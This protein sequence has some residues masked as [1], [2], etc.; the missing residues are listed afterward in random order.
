MSSCTAGP[1][2]GPR[3]ATPAEG[4]WET[5]GPPAAQ[6]SLT[7]APSTVTGSSG[8]GVPRASE[9]DAVPRESTT[10]GT[11]SSSGPPDAVGTSSAATRVTVTTSSQPPPR[12]ATILG[13][14]DVLLHP[15]LWA[16]A[17]ADAASSG[18]TG[19]GA[20]RYDFGPIFAGV[21]GEVA[22][23]D[24]AICELETPVAAPEGPFSGWPRFD[25]PPQVLGTLKQIGYDSCTT[26]SNHTLDQGAAGVTSTLDALD[27]A[28]LAHTGSARSAAEASQ[29]L[30]VTTDSGVRVGQLAYTFGFNGL[31]RPAGKDWMANLID[32]PDILAAAK[33]TRE[34]G[35]DI[36]VLSL[37]WGTEYDHRVTATQRA[38]AREL[39][40]SP[41]IDLILGDHAHVVQPMQRIDGEWVVYG[42]GNQVAR[43]ANPV[44]ASREGI[45]PVITFTEG[46]DG[47]FR[48][49]AAH[50]VPTWMQLTPNLR[51]IDLAGA[52]ADPSLPG[53]Q[54]ADY[55][56][57]VT[58]IRGYVDADGE[59]V[60][61]QGLG[62]QPTGG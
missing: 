1:G 22:A 45:M 18:G 33:R 48:A 32:V 19:S 26:A 9:H 5:G 49:T 37:H 14:G 11:A 50:I 15:P 4:R 62:G 8:I 20:A 34:A 10:G 13:S 27:A 52:L 44:D 42:M 30:I 12:T 23:A 51:L 35:A 24:V 3:G 58:R 40:A 25:V 53:P 47:T 39:L 6:E 41:D 60:P 28:G 16:Q 21:A 55:Q 29:P 46:A 7:A 31:Q 2:A 61:V 17:Q 36:V 57:T 54:R 56:A 59:Q 43:H 38:Q